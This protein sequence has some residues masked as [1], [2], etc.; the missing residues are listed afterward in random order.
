MG[1]SSGLTTTTCIYRK[2]DLP[3][4]TKMNHNS[5]VTSLSI[6]S[7]IL[8]LVLLPASPL[9]TRLLGIAF[10]RAGKIECCLSY[11]DATTEYDL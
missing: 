10:T 4:A 8:M 5:N 2:F 3:R 11:S 9:L 7:L 1:L 6:C